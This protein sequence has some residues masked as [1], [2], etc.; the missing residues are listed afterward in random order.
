MNERNKLN[1]NEIRRVIHYLLKNVDTQKYYKGFNPYTE[2][3]IEA[4]EKLTKIKQLDGWIMF[5]D[6]NN[7]RINL[8]NNDFGCEL[9]LYKDG[10]TYGLIDPDFKGEVSTLKYFSSNITNAKKLFDIKEFTGA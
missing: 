8:K 5:S 9:T 2:K 4:L 6:P 7:Y 1:Q 3:Q 10:H